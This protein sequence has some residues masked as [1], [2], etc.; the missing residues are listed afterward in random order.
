MLFFLLRFAEARR[1]KAKIFLVVKIADKIIKVRLGFWLIT[2]C[3]GIEFRKF[4]RLAKLGDIR[5]FHFSNYDVAKRTLFAKY[6]E[7]YAIS[8]NLA[9]H[10]YRL[11]FAR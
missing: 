11:S 2:F 6:I 7:C 8:T 4:D 3:S 9:F 5:F 1:A 10:F